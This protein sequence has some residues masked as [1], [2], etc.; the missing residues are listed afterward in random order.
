MSL[1]GE[2]AMN[3]TE[4][5]MEPYDEIDQRFWNSIFKISVIPESTGGFVY[6]GKFNQTKENQDEE[7]NVFQFYPE[8]V[9]FT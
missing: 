4:P 1:H 6:Y 2:V 9:N 5:M 7:L 3:F 8:V